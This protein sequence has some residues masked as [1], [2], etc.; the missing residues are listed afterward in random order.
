MV[1]PTALDFDSHCVDYYK[2][3]S[4]RFGP[5]ADRRIKE[6]Y[7]IAYHQPE[8]ILNDVIEYCKINKKH[9][10]LEIVRELIENYD[11][12]ENRDLDKLHQ[13]LEILRARIITFESIGRDTASIRSE[14]RQVKIEQRA[15][16]RTLQPGEEVGDIPDNV[17]KLLELIDTGGFGYVWLAEDRNN[18]RPVAIKVLKSD[19]AEKEG[20]RE[21]FYRGARQM[22]KCSHANI[23]RV[24]SGPRI[25][26]CHNDEFHYFVMEYVPSN[27]RDAVSTLSFEMKI[28]V[29]RS[30]GSALSYAHNVGLIHRDVKPTNILYTHNGVAKLSDFDTVLADDSTGGTNAGQSIGTPL[31]RAPEAT[32]DG[33]AVDVRADVYS[34]GMTAIFLFS[35]GNLSFRDVNE[36]LDRI[37]FIDKLPIPDYIKKILQRSTAKEAKSR[38]GSVEEFCQYLD[39]PDL[40]STIADPPSTATGLVPWVV[41]Q[42]SARL[43]STAKRRNERVR[44]RSPK[45]QETAQVRSYRTKIGNLQLKSVLLLSKIDSLRQFFRGIIALKIQAQ[46]QYASTIVKIRDYFEILHRSVAR[47]LPAIISILAGILVGILGVLMIFHVQKYKVDDLAKSKMS[48]TPDNI[49]QDYVI[50]RPADMAI[51][52]DLSSDNSIVLT[53]PILE[54]IIQGNAEQLLTV[55]FNVLKD[56][57]SRHGNRE[58]VRVGAKLAAMR[59][60]QKAKEDIVLGLCHDAQL[61]L[62]FADVLDADMNELSGSIR[63]SKCPQKTSTVHKISPKLALSAAQKDYDNAR[64][65]SAISKAKIAVQ[66]SPGDAWAIIGKSA[67]HIGKTDLA[68]QALAHVDD[69]EK[70][71]IHHF[72]S[73]NLVKLPDVSKSKA[74]SQPEEQK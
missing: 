37:L 27:L 70:E 55:P 34:L 61:K 49:E 11:S 32:E 22:A 57:M 31:Y 59:I 36:S 56:L 21:R 46:A 30:I 13:R 9:Q 33:A 1:F 29:L 44:R 42:R 39:N 17:Y 74:P 12:P 26:R 60:F 68:G 54:E 19:T 48:K 43:P 18:D 6:S 16:K 53:N 69:K 38:F 14:I 3:V 15:L 73:R 62:D 28:N 41:V 23:V 7:I 24:Y 63:N 10:E 20:H 25:Y 8:R 40:A 50:I 45:E 4:Y 58:N 52:R 65:G 5:N 47:L 64:W 66:R 2:T 35:S 51:T 72:C 71:I 67:C